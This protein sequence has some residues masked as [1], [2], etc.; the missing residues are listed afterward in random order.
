MKGKNGKR[1]TNSTLLKHSMTRVLPR[2][3]STTGEIVVPAVP[4]LLDHYQQMLLSIFASLGRVFND[5][6][7][8]QLRGILEEWL[9]KGWARSPYSRLVVKYETDAPPKTTITYHVSVRYVTIA[10]EYA[11]WVRDR[12]PPLFGAHPD[13]KIMALAGSQAQTEAQE[14]AN[15]Q[16][17]PVLD[18]GAGTG[19]NTLPLARA[20]FP[21]DAVEL[22]PAL[23][24]ILRDEADKEKLAVRVFEGDAT[25]R[26]LGLPA[27]HYRLVV[28]AEVIASHF[29]SVS[30]LR[31]LFEVIADVLRPGGV[32]LF[33]AFVALEG[34][35]P[36]P[37]ARE[38]AQTCWCPIF[39]RGEFDAAMAGLP[40]V[41]VDE[42]STADYERE[43][44]PAEAWPPT[45][46]F[47]QWASGRDLFDLPTG[48]AP[49]ELRWLTYRKEAPRS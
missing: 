16:G 25:D 38:L 22:A 1:E 30:Q 44:Q 3:I 40:F 42:V 43:H 5:E 9:G 47:E 45:G 14:Q 12:T 17:T 20:G 48:R 15:P 13:A 2:K 7:K 6:E 33:N 4:S 19:R 34:Y 39:S 27:N 28:L 36:D 31:S 32:L 37:V 18:I 23:A 49:T 10:D 29:S 11:G 8:K 41:K 46:W 24:A 26:A 21:T 35:R